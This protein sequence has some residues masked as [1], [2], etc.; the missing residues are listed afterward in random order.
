MV[1]SEK[2]CMH[3]ACQVYLSVNSD[4]RHSAHHAPRRSQ[5]SENSDLQLTASPTLRIDA[6][7]GASSTRRIVSCGGTSRKKVVKLKRACKSVD[8]TDACD[9]DE[10]TVPLMR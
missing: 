8:S 9:C 2:G 1:V 4:S 3:A 5:L 6:I 7:Y 10:T